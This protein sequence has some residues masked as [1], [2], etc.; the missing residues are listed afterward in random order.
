MGRWWRRLTGQ[1]ARKLAGALAQGKSLNTLVLELQAKRE[2]LETALSYFRERAKRMDWVGCPH[3]GHE[4]GHVP[5]CMY[6]HMRNWSS[7][8]RSAPEL[9]RVQAEARKKFGEEAKGDG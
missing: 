1:D 9:G 2:G 6:R 5:G 8:A 4:S 7:A 3:C